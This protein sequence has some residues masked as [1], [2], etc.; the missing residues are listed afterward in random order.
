M[1]LNKFS[2]VSCQTCGCAIEQKQGKGRAKR[3]CD[4][5]M[6][7]RYQ[8]GPSTMNCS[9]CGAA[10]VRQGAG[11]PA[12]QC[13]P[14]CKLVSRNR[15]QQKRVACEK[16]HTPFITKTGKGRLCRAC[17]WV[18]PSNGT[19]AA[20]L[21][22]GTSFYRTSSSTQRYCSW[23]CMHDSKRSWHVCKH[24]RV[25]FSRRKYRA[26][27]KREYCCIQCYWDAHGM[28]GS[29]A[30]KAR[31]YG[32]CLGNTRRRCRSFGVP[33]DPKVTIERVAERD[34]YR[35]QL[36][37][38]QC[39]HK[40]LVAKHSRRPHPRNRTVDHIVPLAAGVFGHEWHNVQCACYS[41]NVKKSNRRGYQ[42]RLF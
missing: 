23:R 9:V 31:M 29:K 2:V 30:A 4:A 37:G 5:C 25:S 10:W 32:N 41:C 27:D 11:R 20:C 38:S 28:D 19:A 22:C 34:G 8:A 42:R 33:Y 15:R 17:R 26:G 1:C 14:Q 13:S 39:N 12:K 36:C 18:K 16:C 6:L 35:C 3:Y 40:W 24:C 21:Q 7:R